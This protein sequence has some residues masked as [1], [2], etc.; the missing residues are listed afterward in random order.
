MHYTV[1]VNYNLCIPC[2]NNSGLINSNACFVKRVKNKN[3]NLQNK[4]CHSN[5]QTAF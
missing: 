3:F 4:R 1:D 2:I 5:S